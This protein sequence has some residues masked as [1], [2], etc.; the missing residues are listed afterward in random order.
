[1]SRRP[2]LLEICI[3]PWKVIRQTGSQLI[4]AGD[5]NMTDQLFGDA[6]MTDQLFG[7]ANKTDQLFG[8]TNK[9]D[10]LL[11]DQ[12]ANGQDQQSIKDAI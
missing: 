1:M 11:R 7:D 9:T 4:I 10:Q 8:D 5:A 3:F 12:S 6:K 2:I